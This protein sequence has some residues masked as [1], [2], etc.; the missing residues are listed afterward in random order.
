L[1]QFKIHWRLFLRVRD[2]IKAEKSLERVRQALDVSLVVSVFE[3]YWKDKDLWECSFSIDVTG[4]SDADVAFTCLTLA[5]RLGNGWYLLGP[6]GNYPLEV[7]EG[8]LS[9]NH[10]STAYIAGLDWASFS[11]APTGADC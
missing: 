9:V 6:G 10:S 7:F 5:N 2:R 3:P 4:G 11:L 1:L 8:I